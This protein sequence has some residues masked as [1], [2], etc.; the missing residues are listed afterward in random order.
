MVSIIVFFIHHTC[1]VTTGI[2]EI[3]RVFEGRLNTNFQCWKFHPGAYVFLECG[4]PCSY[5]FITKTWYVVFSFFYAFAIYQYISY[6]PRVAT[7]SWKWWNNWKVFACSEM[8]RNYWRYLAMPKTTPAAKRGTFRPIS[9]ASWAAF[10][11]S[12]AS[13]HSTLIP[14]PPFVECFEICRYIPKCFG[15]FSTSF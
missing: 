12:F 11:F 2:S 10:Y 3:L 4:S 9:S 7:K 13:L 8:L 15:I 5:A 14:H 6:V 1:V